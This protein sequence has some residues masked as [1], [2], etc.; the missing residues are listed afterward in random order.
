[1]RPQDGY[2]RIRGECPLA[3]DTII[4]ETVSLV[5]SGLSFAEHSLNSKT[6]DTSGFIQPEEGFEIEEKNYEDLE[7]IC[8]SAG[9]TYTR[10]ASGPLVVDLEVP[11]HSYRA[12]VEY[13]REG[14]GVMVRLST[15]E[16]LNETSLSALALMLLIADGLVRIVRA[17][18]I[19]EGDRTTVGYEVLIQS[20][21]PT[22]E[23]LIGGLSA[24]SM[25]CRICGHSEIAVIQ[26]ESIAQQ[27]LSV[28]GL[29]L[30]NKQVHSKHY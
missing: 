26:N 10:R 21:L 4:G 9:W 2:L 3:E 30:G 15:F 1:V 19:V 7:S 17:I 20:H 5:C 22:E 14:L 25:V 27:F 13:R 29:G 18:A 23:Q 6:D 24:L 8:S 11:G 16:N 28:H 12:T